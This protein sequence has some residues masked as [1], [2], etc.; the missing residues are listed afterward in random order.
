MSVRHFGDS[1]TVGV[2]ASDHSRNWTSL[3]AARMPWSA[4][5]YAISGSMAWDQA[6]TIY[7][8]L[9]QSGDISTLMLGVNDERIWGDHQADVGAFEDAIMA[10][11][12]WLAIPHGNKMKMAT[13]AQV[14]TTGTWIN[15]VA[16]GLGLTSWTQGSELEFSFNG[17][18][19]YLAY[20]R[21]LNNEGTFD[22]YVDGVKK[23]GGVSCAWRREKTAQNLGY[24]PALL[25][26]DGLGAGDHDCRIVV[27]SSTNSGNRV[28]IDWAATPVDGP[29]VLLATPTRKAPIGHIKF[30]G[31]DF[32]SLIY[33]EA[34]RD[35]AS[36]LAGDGLDV[37]LVDAQNAVSPANDIRLIKENDTDDGVHPNDA[38]HW[39]IHN[40][41][42]KH[43]T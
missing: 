19:L 15:S 12:A 43:L 40:E 13:A 8:T 30:G 5:N 20:I 39:I 27:T 18:V 34:V 10:E 38:G 24:G 28:Y 21:Q 14:F 23:R 11:A 29:I 32:G 22:L 17:R 26:I 6:D 42:W 25:R 41:F 36:Y 37:V 9:V 16:Y 35:V 2:G 31:S 7:S 4:Q 3:L 33:G 1:I